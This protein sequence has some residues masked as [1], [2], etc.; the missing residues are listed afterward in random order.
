MKSYP[1]ME[2]CYREINLLGICLFEMCG[3]HASYVCRHVS[4]MQPLSL[5]LKLQTVAF[6]SFRPSATLGYLFVLIRPCV[7]A[8]SVSVRHAEKSVM[9]GPLY[10]TRVSCY[11]LNVGSLEIYKCTLLQYKCIVLLQYCRLIQFNY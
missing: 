3:Q 11:S 2:C 10:S 4:V 7:R 5:A 8:A 1:K 9:L 6:S